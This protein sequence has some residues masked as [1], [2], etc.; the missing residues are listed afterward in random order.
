MAEPRDPL[1]ELDAGLARLDEAGLRRRVQPLVR[2]VVLGVEPSGQR[3][4]FLGRPG[5][6]RVF[7]AYV[8]EEA[9]TQ[10]D[11]GQA[12]DSPVQE[13]TQAR[14]RVPG[15]RVFRAHRTG[16][17]HGRTTPQKVPSI[18]QYLPLT[19]YFFSSIRFNASRKSAP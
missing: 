8:L 16:K 2:V 15:F 9:P 4:V 19:I 3:H 17:R 7:T 10:F 14:G 6:V 12:G 18:H 5:R 13:Q 11:L 1:D